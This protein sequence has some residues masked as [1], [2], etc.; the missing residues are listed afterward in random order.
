M[1]CDVGGTGQYIP[2][3][4]E[5]V[6]CPMTITAEIPVNRQ[7]LSQVYNKGTPPTECY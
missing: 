2:Y 6:P 7:R 3:K 4:Q 5:S 1:I